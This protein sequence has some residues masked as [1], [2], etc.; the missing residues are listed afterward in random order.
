[1]D[2]I[3]TWTDWPRVNGWRLDRGRFFTEA[4]QEGRR[5]VA[6][7]G[8]EVAE[9]LFPEYV[10]PIGSWIRLN[11]VQFEVIGVLA[12]KGDTGFR[13]Q[14]DTVVVPL[15][16][17]QSRLFGT[18]Y[19]SSF[20]AEARSDAHVTMATAELESILRRTH[21][22]RPAVENDFTITGQTAFLDLVAETGQTFTLLLAGIAGVSLVVGGVGIMNIMLVSVTER[23]REIG[24]RKAMGAT[25]R[26]IR[27]QFLIEALVLSTLG[28]TLGISLGWAASEFFQW[29]LGWST[30]VSLTAV[31]LAFGFSAT[32]GIVFGLYPAFRAARL[33]PIEALRYE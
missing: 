12:S 1:M 11:G 23:T 7:V 29:R 9:D 4:E 16:T 14:D 30:L 20:V 6:V 26:S 32:V 21:R 18:E 3:G 13:N 31:V 15:A 22:L 24:V 33:D 10:D 27:L 17:A 2:V 28:G 8:S 19:L 5:R 25:R